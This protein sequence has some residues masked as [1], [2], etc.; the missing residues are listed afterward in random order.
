M[1]ITV[2]QPGELVAKARELLTG[3][4]TLYVPRS[5]SMEELGEQFARADAVLS[6]GNTAIG[7]E[8]LAHASPR[9]QV[10]SIIGVGYDNVDVGAA[11]KRNIQIANLPGINARAVAEYTLAAILALTRGLVTGNHHSKR[12]EWV[13]A[14]HFTGPQLDELVCGIIGLGHIG[15]EVAGILQA[16]GARVLGYDPAVD[17]GLLSGLEV[18]RVTLDEL[19]SSCQVVT[20]HVPLLEATREMLGRSQL[21]AM[22]PGSY[23][24]NSARAGVIDEDALLEALESG[25]LAGAAIDVYPV[26]PPDLSR[27]LYGLPQVLV[28]PH[29]AAMTHRAVEDMQVEAAHNIAA[30]L[31][32]EEPIHVVNRE[33]L[34]R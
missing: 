8:L 29:V 7:E 32:G 33:L 25:H 11:S 6:W 2:D 14:S 4:G 9:L 5:Q 12:G 20:L 26:E 3:L 15:R 27:S 17:P 13:L 21:A 18:E 1:Y 30:V 19:L 31:R 28:T 16:L 23:V 24:I 10:I 34:G 22:P